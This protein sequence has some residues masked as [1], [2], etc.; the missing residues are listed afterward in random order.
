ML[1]ILRSAFWLGLVFCIAPGAADDPRRESGAI[2]VSAAAIAVGDLASGLPRQAQ[3]ACRKAPQECVA[4][5]QKLTATTVAKTPSPTSA[6]PTRQ[7]ESKRQEGPHGRAQDQ[8]AGAAA[9]RD[10]NSRT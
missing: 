6:A 7:R 4:M 8:R 5:A 3:A 2:A 9:S 1:F 10:R